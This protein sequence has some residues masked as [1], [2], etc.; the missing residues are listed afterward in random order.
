MRSIHPAILRSFLLLG[1]SLFLGV[2]CTSSQS[3]T[4][5]LMDDGIYFDPD[6]SVAKPMVKNPH[7]EN[8]PSPNDAFD[9][10]DP[11]DASQAANA[12]SGSGFMPNSRFNHTP[13]FGW[14]MQNGWS[15]GLG[16]GM[17]MGSING[18]NMGLGFGN[19]WGM[20][21]N[22]WGMCDPFWDP[23]CD[24]FM[25]SI[26][27]PWYSPWNNPWA[28]GFG[29]PYWNGFNNGFYLGSILNGNDQNFI[30]NRRR[31]SAPR[32]GGGRNSSGENAS[33]NG[34]GKRALESS[35]AIRNR[36]TYQRTAASG[37]ESSN[38]RS[39]TSSLSPRNS[40]VIHA[41]SI[42]TN[43]RDVHNRVSEW[44]ESPRNSNNGSGVRQTDRLSNQSRSRSFT[45]QERNQWVPERP[46]SRQ[47]PGNQSRT[48]E[49]STWDR[50]QQ[51]VQERNNRSFDRSYENSRSSSPS[52]SPAPSRSSGSTPATRSNSGRGR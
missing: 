16:M 28:M 27:N 38:N 20:M 34:S 14:G 50:M 36:E 11:S 24:P 19:N 31:V 40:A 25:G 43:R 6:Y 5:N 45:D 39:Q 30:S 35:R 51:S 3:L 8:A 18:W 1:T 42:S 26:Y 41:E 21:G 52:S 32:P 37:S 15:M 33:N 49:R 48:Q 17:G 4:R 22:G 47:T 10:F 29:N 2:A 44:V 46:A 12:Q 23:F 7:A 13:G 9:Y